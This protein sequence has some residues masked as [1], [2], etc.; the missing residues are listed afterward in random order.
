[1]SAEKLP[2]DLLSD[3]HRASLQAASSI[4]PEVVLER[5]YR[6]VTTKAALRDLGF[7]TNQQIVPAL[8]LPVFNVHGEVAGYQTR[9]DSPRVTKGKP[10]KYETVSG[11]RMLLDVH[12]AVRHLL[13][14]PTV[15]L[16]VT[17]GIKKG[18]SLAS[19]NLCAVALLGV[20]NWRGTNADGGKVALADWESVALNGRQVYIVFDSDVMQKRAVHAA[21]ERLKAFLESRSATVSLIYLP[22]GMNGAKQGIDDYLAAG[23]SV[24]QLFALA[25]SELIEFPEGDGE[26]HDDDIDDQS[27]STILVQLASA[28]ELFHDDTFNGYA[29]VEID[30]HRET[31]ALRSTGFKRWLMGIFY[32]TTGRAAKS[33]SFS[34][35]LTVIESRA[36]FE[37]GVR[38]VWL[39]T[40]QGDDGCSY[41]DLGDESW[42]AVRVAPDGW[43]IVDVPPVHF[44]RGSTSARLPEPQRGGSLEELRTVINI[45]DDDDFKRVVGWLL[46]ALRPRGPYPVLAF[47]AEQGSGKTAAARMLCALV[48]PSTIQ[49]RG[50]ISDE[51]DL[52]IA[53]RYS[54]IMA[55]DN[56]SHLP[57]WLSD[58]F[59]RIATG[60]GFST[61]RL[62]TDADEEVF[63]QTRPI[64]I[65]GI[66]DYVSNGDLLDRTMLIGLPTIAP[67]ARRQESKLE[68]E[69]KRIQPLALGALLDAACASLRNVDNV[70]LTSLPR[71]ADFAAWVVAAEG[72]LGWPEG[73]F[74]RAYLA[75]ANEAQDVVLEASP[76]GEPIRDLVSDVGEWEGTAKDLLTVLSGRVTEETRRSRSWP[77]SARGIS[78]PLRRLAPTLRALGIEVGF[79]RAPTRART[80]TVS[81]R[82][83][84]EDSTVQTVQPSERPLIVDGSDGSDELI[85]SSAPVDPSQQLGWEMEVEATV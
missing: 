77:K 71:M 16:F 54:H 31:W 14:N 63:T 25:R 51:R 45:P 48:D 85:P 67:L 20:W 58:A 78:G 37:N 19:R 18:D 6:T 41:L 11:Q 84:R 60:G 66:D 36:Q 40:A 59:C 8:L 43:T 62:Y 30:G 70:E 73:S 22:L 56:V 3:N 26:D 72:E 75:G 42:R 23:G 80:R 5:G 35:A 7:S 76:I 65:T 64:L 39:R 34:D 47:V 53:A 69:Y 9:P 38:P 79:N 27:M 49:L 4:Q 68:T 1:M 29:V 83:I 50:S 82:E 12:P 46:G 33:A 13:A 52:V 10:V 44:L 57:Q 28:C 17:E 61:R 74:L 55:F 15:P 32:K 21:L 2:L 24:G 81:L